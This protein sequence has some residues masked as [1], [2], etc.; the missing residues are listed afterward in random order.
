[1]VTIKGRVVEQTTKGADEHI[2]KLAKK[3]LNAERYPAHSPNVKRII[4]LDN[5]NNNRQNSGQSLNIHIEG[6]NNKVEVT[7][8]NNQANPSP[9]D[10]TG[11]DNGRGNGYSDIDRIPNRQTPDHMTV[12]H[13]FRKRYYILIC[14]L[15]RPI[16]STKS[17]PDRPC[18]SKSSIIESNDLSIG[19]EK[20]NHSIIYI[21]PSSRPKGK[22]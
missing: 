13:R 18:T 20:D 5:N 3:Y 12:L 8:N 16:P 17:K 4:F 9:Q 11:R 19:L 21:L 6:N 2:D 14:L 1:M 15:C 7:Q 10:N 22:C